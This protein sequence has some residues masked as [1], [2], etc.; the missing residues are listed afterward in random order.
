VY[1]EVDGRPFV[2]SAEEASVVEQVIEGA[3]IW[4]AELAAVADPANRARMVAF[5]DTSLETLG[6]RLRAGPGAP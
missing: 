3:R 6:R 2:P 4:V 5:L 1:V